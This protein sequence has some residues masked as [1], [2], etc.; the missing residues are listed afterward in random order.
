M[1]ASLKPGKLGVTRSDIV[2]TLKKDIE[3]TLK[4]SGNSFLSSEIRPVVAAGEFKIHKKGDKLIIIF[5]N[6]SGHYRPSSKSV[7][8][9]IVR[10]TLQDLVKQALDR[11]D[12][13]P[14]LYLG[15]EP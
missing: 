13:L 15:E 2:A 4:N 14:I 9:R 3:E 7:N 6:N 5:D 10:N 1:L 12:D 8:S 11:D